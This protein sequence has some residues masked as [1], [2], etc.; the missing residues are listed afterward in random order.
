MTLER[1]AYKALESVV[2]PENISEDPAVLLGYQYAGMNLGSEL[3]GGFLPF[4]PE[5]V[6]LPKNTEEVQ[7][8]ILVCVR[9]NIKCKA[10]SIA[11]SQ[12]EFQR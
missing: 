3:G 10:H 4:A 6:V 8:I 12:S 1:N 2:G 5:A 7:G 11:E 9:Y